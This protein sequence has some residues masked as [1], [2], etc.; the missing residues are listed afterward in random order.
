MLE[1][2]GLCEGNEGGAKTS[3]N[4]DIHISAITSGDAQQRFALKRTLS[5]GQY[6]RAKQLTIFSPKT[7]R[8]CAPRAGQGHTI[9]KRFALGPWRVLL[10]AR[11]TTKSVPEVNLRTACK[12]K[13]SNMLAIATAFDEDE[14][15]PMPVRPVPL[16]MHITVTHC[17][18]AR[19]TIAIHA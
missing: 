2:T 19:R 12:V 1:G 4:E 3:R 15:D 17:K 6:P 11:C 9:P 5:I 10:G 7:D 14:L 18:S 16:N 8:H 13:Q